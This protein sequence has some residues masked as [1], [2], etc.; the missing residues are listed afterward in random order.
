MEEGCAE[1]YMQFVESLKPLIPVQAAFAAL[2]FNVSRNKVHPRD[3]HC[4]AWWVL[5]LGEGDFWALRAAEEARVL[6][7]CGLGTHW[8]GED[9][10]VGLD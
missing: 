7:V 8:E 4:G 6:Y 2:P 5:A 3:M 1:E 9:F 10:T